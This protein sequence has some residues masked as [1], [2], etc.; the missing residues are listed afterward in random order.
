MYSI[1]YT[2]Y[3]ILLSNV[4]MSGAGAMAIALFYSTGRELG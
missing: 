1:L 4:Y 2:V 3:C